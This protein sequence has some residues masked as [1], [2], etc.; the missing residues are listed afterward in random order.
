MKL[1]RKHDGMELVLAGD[2]EPVPD[3][4]IKQWE[5]CGSD[6]V[7]LTDGDG[8]LNVKG[9]YETIWTPHGYRWAWDKQEDGTLVIERKVQE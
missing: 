6:V 8:G 1:K 2:W 3:K 5:R 4:P 9:I 7:S